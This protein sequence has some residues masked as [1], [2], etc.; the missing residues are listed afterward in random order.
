MRR[1]IRSRAAG[2]R[3]AVLLVAAFWLV[4][5]TQASDGTAGPAT[6][7]AVPAT[8]EA[9]PSVGETGGPAT[10]EAAPSVG[11]APSEGG[12][13]DRWAAEVCGTVGRWREDVRDVVR[14]VPPAIADAD[15][16]EEAE[17][18]IG[19]TLQSIADGSRAA[20][21]QI[22]DAEL[23]DTDNRAALESELDT[24]Q[25]SIDDTGTAIDEALAEDQT[26]TQLASSV[27]AAVTTA[28]QSLRSV[29][30]AWDR[31]G[32]LDM[33]AEVE[34]ALRDNPDCQALDREK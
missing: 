2:Q 3:R 34:A 7:E 21:G 15:S 31:I 8:G 30:D 27:A 18:A 22:A 20:A 23:P 13:A 14:T 4:A 29:S 1:D 10:S 32:Q 19:T 9:A 11:G 25:Q 33:G 12:D 16:R 28:E 5:C 26:L 24:I 6:G 17:A